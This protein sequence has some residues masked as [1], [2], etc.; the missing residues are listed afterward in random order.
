MMR[1]GITILIAGMGLAS[2]AGAVEISGQGSPYQAI[3]QR[4]AFGLSPPPTVAALPPKPPIPPPKITL[5]GVTTILGIR[6]AFLTMP[7]IKLGEPAESFILAEGQR[8]YDIEVKNID[9]KAGVVTIV[10]HGE[11]Q[12]LDF[13]HDGAKA[14]GLPPDPAPRQPMFQ[15]P[16]LPAPARNETAMTPEEQTALIE[17]Q[18]VKYQ[19]ENNPI[20]KILPATEMT[21]ETPQ[22]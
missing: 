12:I 22:N 4:N 14:P 8:I 9:E 5:T 19:Q 18:R 3:V 11:S 16:V 1:F 7:G 17:V 6:M 20:H 2:P 10:N 21:P 13:D 15:R